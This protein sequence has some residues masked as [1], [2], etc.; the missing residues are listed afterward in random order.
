MKWLDQREMARKERMRETRGL[1]C[2]G[3]FYP[4]CVLAVHSSVTSY[5]SCSWLGDSN[6]SFLHAGGS[7]RWSC[8]VLFCTVTTGTVCDVPG[9]IYIFPFGVPLI[10]LLFLVPC[11]ISIG[12]NVFFDIFFF[13]CLVWWHVCARYFV[14]LSFT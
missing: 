2:A 4:E 14:Q 1:C 3:S 8:F 7:R 6:K 5:D 12:L 9:S 11:H 10:F 13:S